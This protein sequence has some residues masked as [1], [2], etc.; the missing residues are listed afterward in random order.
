MLYILCLLNQCLPCLFSNKC[1]KLSN[2]L[3]NRGKKDYSRNKNKKTFKP[4][5]GKRRKICLF[6]GNKEK[7]IKPINGKH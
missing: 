5:K 4:I 1:N 6:S 2:P 3:I 7:K